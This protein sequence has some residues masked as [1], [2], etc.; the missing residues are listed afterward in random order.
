[1]TEQSSQDIK[2]RK[3][4]RVNDG[5]KWKVNNKEWEDENDADR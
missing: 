4:V 2:A 1:M 5:E 3:Q